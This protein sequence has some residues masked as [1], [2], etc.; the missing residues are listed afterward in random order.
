MYT[1]ADLR[2]LHKLYDPSGKGTITKA[3]A[4]TAF[5]NLG[6]KTAPAGLPEHVD[7][8]SFVAAGK[9]AIDAEK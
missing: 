2:A 7:E 8:G 5:R 9:A 6:L 3:Q 1:E 4:A